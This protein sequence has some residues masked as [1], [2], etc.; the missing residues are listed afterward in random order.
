MINI[1]FQKL[2]ILIIMV[3]QYFPSKVTSYFK[4][5]IISLIFSIFSQN[6]L[7]AQSIIDKRTSPEWQ[8]KDNDLLVLG[9]ALYDI[10]YK[11][12]NQEECQTYLKSI[13]MKEG[14]SDLVSKEV[15]EKV[16]ND[17]EPIRK[18]PGGS[19]CN[20][21]AGLASFGV[22]VINSFVAHDNMGQQYINDMQKYGVDSFI[23]KVNGAEKQE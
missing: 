16:M 12:D 20:T 4:Y 15:I 21:A 3:S 1:A 9:Q 19:G 17:L 23:E 18:Q 11:F 2:I 22:K 8:K 5:L 14:S 13:N 10:I 6:I 7:Y